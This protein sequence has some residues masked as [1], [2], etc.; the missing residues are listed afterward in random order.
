[1]EGLNGPGKAAVAEVGSE[2]TEIF[3]KIM[4]MK[5]LIS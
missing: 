4:K 1:L 5:S 2:E 3:K